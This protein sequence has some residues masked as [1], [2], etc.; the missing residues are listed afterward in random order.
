M[1]KLTKGSHDGPNAKGI[2]AGRFSEELDGRR[3]TR[4][5]G[6]PVPGE[7]WLKEK[8]WAWSKK[9]HFMIGLFDA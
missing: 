4:G 9:I 2:V 6:I 7:V 5:S 8:V 3:M 1:L